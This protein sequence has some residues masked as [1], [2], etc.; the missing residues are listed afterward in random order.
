MKF[1]LFYTD[2]RVFGFVKVLLTLEDQDVLADGSEIIFE[3]GINQIPTGIS[4]AYLSHHRSVGFVLNTYRLND[5]PV[6]ASVIV[7]ETRALLTLE[8]ENNTPVGRFLQPSLRKLPI[9]LPL[10]IHA[11][12][13]DDFEGLAEFQSERPCK[14]TYFS[15][16]S[17]QQFMEQGWVVLEFAVD[18]VLLDAACSQ[19][20]D[21]ARE[22]YRGYIEGSSSRIEHLHKIPGAI[23]DIYF[24]QSLRAAISELYGTP[25]SPCQTLSYR[26][27]SQQSLHSDYVHL[28]P[29]P[30]NLM[31]GVWIALEDVHPDA[32][33]LEFVPYSHRSARLTMQDF[34]LEQIRDGD[35]SIFDTTFSPAW[36][37]AV[38]G[39]DKQLALLRKGQVLIWD[40]NLIH[41]GTSR[42]QES[43]TRSSVV[44]HF[45]GDGAVCLY[46]ALGD[47][48]NPG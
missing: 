11:S 47:V 7:N 39:L 17:Y 16:A 40:G 3:Y 30:R 24:S 2:S 37:K 34:D 20:Q 33:P 29:F 35:Y 31:C 46:D 26:Y 43:L 32:G 12:I 22:G 5:G 36:E 28:T 9:L 8:V 1:D 25:M 13:F 4:I 38:E 10:P 18:P 6:R 27:G 48:G 41:G 42:R 19:L 14:G 21:A 45:F 15:E 23:R 44:L